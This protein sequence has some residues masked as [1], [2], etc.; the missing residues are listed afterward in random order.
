MLEILSFSLVI[1]SV[2]TQ[3]N[4]MELILVQAMW[5]NG[6]ISPVRTYKNDPFQAANW[7]FGGGGFGQLSTVSWK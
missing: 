1:Q 2:V 3:V 4:K 5:N 7:T 6:D